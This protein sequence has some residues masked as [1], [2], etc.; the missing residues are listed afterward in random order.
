MKQISDSD[1]EEDIPAAFARALFYIPR[2][3][4]CEMRGRGQLEADAR[5]G[6]V[7]RSAERSV[8]RTNPRYVEHEHRTDRIDVYIVEERVESAARE[9]HLVC[10]LFLRAVLVNLGK[11]SR[12]RFSQCLNSI[13]CRADVG[14]TERAIQ[15]RFAGLVHLQ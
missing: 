7:A 12:H 4:E 2:I 8:T 1:S 6:T 9:G 14:I 3:A 11:F 15:I 5:A 13:R 10:R